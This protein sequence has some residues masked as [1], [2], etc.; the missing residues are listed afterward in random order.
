VTPS[1]TF[2]STYY[3]GQLQDGLFVDQGLFR[4]TGELSIDIR[5]P[6]IERLWS[7]NGTKWKHVIEPEVV[8]RYVTGVNAFGK[9]VRFDED[10]T[11]TD[12]NEFQYGFTQR[13]FRRDANGRTEELVTWKLTEKYFF[14][15]TFGGALVPGQRNVFET[16]D[17]LT[18]FAFADT[19]RHF[20]PIVSDLT[21]EPGKR[22]DSEFIVNYDPVRDKLTAIGGLAKLKPYSESFLTLAYFSTVNL[23]VNP[24]PVP[25][26]FEQRSNQVRAMI[27]YGD[28]NRRGWNAAFG[29]SYDITEQTF[30][31][32]LAEGS[33]NTSCCGIGFEIRRFSFGNIRNE[34]LYMGVFRIANLGSI[35]NL[36]R[37]EKIF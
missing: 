4:N 26:N 14:D 27:G 17:Q 32:Q 7:K 11:L 13:L 20:S 12:T 28:V 2:R 22:Y 25:P 23:P 15:P 1:F 8:Y 10:D 30:Q 37:Q 24:V 19:E 35:G 36:R 31:N 6:V 33:Y 21:I 16:L 18:P 3:G 9:L 34:D 29:A 5:P